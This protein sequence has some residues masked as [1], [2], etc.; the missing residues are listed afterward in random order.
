MEPLPP[1]VIAALTPKDVQITFHDDRIA[2]IPFDLPTDLVAM[3]IE[4]YTAKRAYQIASEYR[5]R[6]IPVVMGGFHASL[7]PDEVAQ[8]AETVVVGEAEDIW[9]TVIEDYKNGT[10][11]KFYTAP[12]RPELFKST[13]DRS[14]FRDKK[15]LSVQLVEAGRGC[16]LRCE[17]CAIQTVY[18]RS[19]NFRPMDQIL[20]EVRSLRDKSD[21]FFFVDDNIVTNPGK[22]KE[23][24][25]E[26]A[27]LKIKWVS[28]ATIS[29]AK[30]EELLQLMQ[31]SGCQ[32]VLIGFE[33]LKAENLMLMDKSINTLGIDYEEAMK[34]FQRYKIRIYGT[35]V[36]G[37]DH[38]VVKSFEES[39][40]FATRHAFFLTGFNH[41]TP[42]PGTTLY[43]RLEQEKRLIYDKW[44][45]DD[46]YSY[47]L[48]PFRPKLMSA[49]E[50][51]EQCINARRTFYSYSNIMKR[52]VHSVNQGF[53]K[54]FF[55]MNLMHHKELAKRDR[56]P[57][58]DENWT[59]VLLKA[60]R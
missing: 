52:L 22:A 11:K 55:L 17:F 40:E 9:E 39:V 58:G 49:E 32:G 34:K 44:W 25:R 33:S 56:Y 50:V 30:D 6:H 57:L 35:F 24:F 27:A 3:S 37:Y 19:Q 46:T 13:P 59:G 51:H 38:D 18:K 8:Y 36:F 54:P 42:F 14:I 45:M 20:S 53:R 15:Y 16:S 28:Q 26:L 31:Q 48:L 29:A 1:A 43:K 5:R 10:A 4:T 60:T 12:T 7:C 47:N 2:P 41:L 21:F 23:F